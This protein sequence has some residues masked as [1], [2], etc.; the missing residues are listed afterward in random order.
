MFDCSEGEAA[1]IRIISMELGKNGMGAAEVTKLLEQGV[2]LHRAG[3]LQDAQECYSRVLDRDP[4]HADALNLL[5]TIAGERKRFAKAVDFFE[6][7]IRLKP[8]EP[9]YRNNL[10]NTLLRAKEYEL[11][12]EQLEEAVRLN[13]R[14][15]DA[16]CNLAVAYSACGHLED[17]RDTLG[18]VKSLEPK[19]RRV[20]LLLAQMESRGGLLDKAVEGYRQVL[21][22]EPSLAALQ[23]ILLTEKATPSTREVA[24]AEAILR[25]GDLDNVQRSVLLHALGK[26]Y[27]DLGRYDEA[28]SSVIKAKQ[29][30]QVTFDFDRHREWVEATRS[31]FTEKF[32]SDRRDLGS[33]SQVPVFI[34]GMPRSG[35]TLVEQIIASHPQAHGAGELPHLRRIAGIVGARLPGP[36]IDREALTSFAKDRAAELAHLYLLRLTSTAGAAERVSDK[37]PLNGLYLGVAALL[38]PRAKILYC[39][40]NPIDTCVSIF[41]QKFASRHAYSY[42]LNTLGR[43]YRSFAELMEHWRRLLPNTILEVHYENTVDDLEAEARAIISFLGLEWSDSC[44]KFQDAERAV[45]TAS[46]WQVRQPVYKTSV[47]RWR[48]YEKHLAPLIEGLGNMATDADSENR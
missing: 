47:Q 4:S 5:G 8:R 21:A 20:P 34:V 16:L 10:G 18:K 32:M 2:A 24:D 40:R 22:N 3:K 12:I 19:N 38:F 44:L 35:T 15:V 27:D 46:K 37:A 26:A 7:A 36:A 25:E 14:Y 23:G 43:F 28:I 48:R 17:A 39:R 1:R 9:V 13:P 41:M 11:A 30:E 33:D 6:K 45:M 42:D 31:I 29:L